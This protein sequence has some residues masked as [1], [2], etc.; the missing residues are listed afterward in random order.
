MALHDRRPARP[1]RSLRVAVSLGAALALGAVPLVAQVTMF[2]EFSIDTTLAGDGQ[3]PHV[4]TTAVGQC[5]GRL[6][7]ATGRLMLACSS[8]VAG[9]GQLLLSEGAPADGG[10]TVLVLGSGPVVGADVT[11]SEMRVAELLTG[12][13]YLAVTS[14]DHPQGEIAARV[15]PRQPVGDRV[16]RF[17][18]AAD[19]LVSSGSTA[20]GDCLLVFH[21]DLS[22]ALLCVHDVAAPQQLEVLIDNNTVSTVSATQNPLQASLPV[23]GNQFSRF[24]AGNFGV[25]LTSLAHPEGELGMVLDHC[26]GGPETLCLHGERFAVS[27][28]FTQPGQAP[29]TAHTVA[30]NADD[31]G[32]FWFFGPSNWEVTLKVL[33]GCS[34]N[35]NFWVFLS[36]NTNVAFTATVFD[37]AT[38]ATRRYSNPQG[39]LAVPV[40]DTSA[41]SCGT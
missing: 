18:L 17:P 38:G 13:L 11:L 9:A 25:V 1:R 24:L 32:L 37:T 33:D 3:T 40:A 14:G 10:T 12:R 39:K 19:S 29:A 41:I 35:N 20:S 23:L 7:P 22:N 4:A 8:D 16:M 28:E 30:G 6:V 26:L 27:I 5:N 15:L 21:A 34:F 2:G 31:S 36:A